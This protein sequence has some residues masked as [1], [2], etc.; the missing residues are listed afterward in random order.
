MS[1]ET[2]LAFCTTLSEK[3]GKTVR[4]PTE[5][6]REYACRAGTTTRFPYGDDPEY[7]QLDDYAW[8]E[9]NAEHK[10][11]KGGILHNHPV[12]EGVETGT[13]L[14]FNKPECQY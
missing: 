13:Q 7:A 4:L 3:T 1:Y 6:E 11:D 2:A 12:G 9:K 5:A 8:Y 10:D 14:V